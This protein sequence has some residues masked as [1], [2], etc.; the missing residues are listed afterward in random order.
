MPIYEYQSINPD[1]ACSRCSQGFEIFQ[2]I[3]EEPLSACIYC[4]THVKKIISM[5]RAAVMEY[6]EAHKKVEN[7]INDYEKS[8]M[9][10]HAAELADKQSE[11]TRDKNLKTRALE[12][13]K[14]AGYDA[15]ALSRHS[16]AD[17]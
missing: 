5:C 16:K 9:W 2:K 17:E 11:K 15:D 7:R 6:S 1:G 4:G 12:N 10:S 14:Q 13:Y 8:G 3:N